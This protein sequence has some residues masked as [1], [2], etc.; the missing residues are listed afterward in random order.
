MRFTNQGN[1]L[2]FDKWND[3]LFP[4]GGGGGIEEEIEQT[5]FTS[6]ISE[7]QIWDPADDLTVNGNNAL[8]IWA[9]GNRHRNYIAAGANEMLSPVKLARKLRKLDKASAGHV[10]VWSCYAG[11]PDG[12]VQHFAAAMQTLGYAALHFWGHKNITSNMERSNNGNQWADVY[13]EAPTL[14]SAGDLAS[15]RA[16]A[17]YGMARVTRQS[18][19]GYGPGLGVPFTRAYDV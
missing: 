12:F 16:G 8:W 14:K 10:I 2:Q 17:N 1:F 6:G 11:A 5:L 19:S 9:H 7:D 3:N 18:L 13:G 15:E 4:I